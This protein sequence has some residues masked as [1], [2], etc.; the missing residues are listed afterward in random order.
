VRESYSI[1]LRRLSH[2]CT[3]DFNSFAVME[4]SIKA[5]GSSSGKN[6]GSGEASMVSVKRQDEL[7]EMRSEY[8]VHVNNY[9]FLNTNYIV[10][11]VE[12]K[13][14]KLCEKTQCT[15]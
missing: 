4:A 11:T 1:D 8:T 2:L 6:D 7:T 3:F 5:P 14:T 13:H 9:D 10:S 12:V 15:L